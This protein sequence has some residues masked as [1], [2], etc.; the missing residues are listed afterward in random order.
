MMKTAML[1]TRLWSTSFGTSSILRPRAPAQSGRLSTGVQLQRP[2]SHLRGQSNLTIYSCRLFSGSNRPE[3]EKETI[4]KVRDGDKGSPGYTESIMLSL[5]KFAEN[6]VGSM[7]ELWVMTKEVAHHYW[8]G[9]KLL[10]QEMKLASSILRRVLAGHAMTRRERLQLI[11]TAMDMFR[12]VPFAIFVIVPFMEL[13]LPL[14]LKLFPNMLPSTFQDKLKKEETM[15]KELQARLGVANF[16]QETLTEMATKKN[17]VDE[18]EGERSTA[19]EVL[20]FIEAAKKGEPLPNSQVLKI[21]SLFKDELTLANASSSQL[22]RLCQYMGLKPFGSDGFLRFKLR[23]K[24]RSIKEDDRRILWEGIDSLTIDELQDACQERGMRS[25]GL[26]EYIYKRQLQDWLDLSIQKNTPISLLI[27]SRAFSL[28]SNLDTNADRLVKSISSLEPD[29]INEVVLSASSPS[30]ENSVDMKKRRLD[31]IEFQK[32]LI[33]DEREEAEEAKVMQAKAKEGQQIESAGASLGTK[34]YIDRSK[35]SE[36]LELTLQEIEV[37]GELARGSSAVESER[38]QLNIIKASIACADSEKMSMPGENAAP[39]SEEGLKVRDA[40]YLKYIFDNV[41]KYSS[42]GKTK[43]GTFAINYY[44]YLYQVFLI[45]I[46]RVFSFFR[47]VC[48]RFA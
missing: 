31:S 40:N 25:F 22:V 7:K 2:I 12:L 16:L 34:E 8:L 33:A 6:P 3:K 9:S 36:S 18:P 26:H 11:R 41:I 29:V 13:L 21:A 45:L 42:S 44:L 27:M 20:E 35:A 32:E 38:L 17:S 10:W 48:R 23:S 43:G 39:L 5:K 19:K 24:M 4:Q 15:K 30:E 28:T 46:N 37:L 47:S 14:A 1:R